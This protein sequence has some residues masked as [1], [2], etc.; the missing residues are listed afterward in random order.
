MRVLQVRKIMSVRTKVSFYLFELKKLVFIIL[1][2]FG[3]VLLFVCFRLIKL[4]GNVS[5]S[6]LSLLL[7]CV[8]FPILSRLILISFFLIF[9][10]EFFFFFIFLIPSFCSNL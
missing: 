8:A 7:L 5:G 4:V 6:T 2:L 9:I 3:I 1:L 10:Y